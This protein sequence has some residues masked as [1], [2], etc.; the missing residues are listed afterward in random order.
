VA[1]AVAREYIC[2]WGAAVM[3]AMYYVLTG[4]SLAVV[5]ALTGRRVTPTVDQLLSWEVSL[6]GVDPALLSASEAGTATFKWLVVVVR[7]HHHAAR[8]P[9]HVL[10]RPAARHPICHIYSSGAAQT[11]VVGWTCFCFC[12]CLLLAA[13][14]LLP[15]AAA[16]AAAAAFYRRPR[17]LWRCC[18]GCFWCRS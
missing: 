14:C 17:S 8:S 7:T 16:A 6:V 15:A 3:Q 13:C 10:S 4:L 9:A 1:V 5:N 11:I 12:R 2:W 18:W